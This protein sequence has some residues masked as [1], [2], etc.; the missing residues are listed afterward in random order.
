MDMKYMVDFSCGHDEEVELFGPEK[1]RR[2][3]IEYWRREGVCTKCYSQSRESKLLEDHNPVR[4]KYAQY[5]K[6]FSGC[7]TRSDSY[8]KT[9]RTILVYVPKELA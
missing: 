8:D 9:D 5:K 4:M 2:Q 3:K 6:Q 7:K 1:N